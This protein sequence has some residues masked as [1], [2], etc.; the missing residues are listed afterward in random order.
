[1]L[2]GII[3]KLRQADSDGDFDW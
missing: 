2:K 1:M 3:Q